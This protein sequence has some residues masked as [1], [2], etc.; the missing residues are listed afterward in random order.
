[1]VPQVAFGNEDRI[2][3]GMRFGCFGNIC[4]IRSTIFEELDTGKKYYYN[5]STWAVIG[6]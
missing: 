5:G 3:L 4:A 1:M 6:G 2:Y